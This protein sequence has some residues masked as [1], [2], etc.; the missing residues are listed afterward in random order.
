MDELGRVTLFGVD[1]S[2]LE[3]RS[4]ELLDVADQVRS[5]IRLVKEPSSGG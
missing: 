5:L 1:K 2:T 4:Y 3:L